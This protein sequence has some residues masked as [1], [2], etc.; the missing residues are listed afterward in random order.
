MEFS[1]KTGETALDRHGTWTKRH[2]YWPSPAHMWLTG[3]F[4]V[5]INTIIELHFS[6]NTL[7]PSL[8]TL[9]SCSTCLSKSCAIPKYTSHLSHRGPQPV[10]P[11]IHLDINS[12][13]KA[14]LKRCR[15]LTL[16]L[17]SWE[18]SAWRCYFSGV[19]MQH[20]NE[21][22]YQLKASSWSCLTASRHSLAIHWIA[23]KVNSALR[24]LFL[25][26]M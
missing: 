2:L 13:T 14:P 10:T 22:H 21:I 3:P 24:Q 16:P 7:I 19:P 18:T 8:P 26:A 23:S 6:Q 12:L 4:Y 9:G 5:Y 25:L 20:W 1:Q 15:S 11:F 17:P